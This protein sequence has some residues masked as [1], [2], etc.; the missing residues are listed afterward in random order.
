MLHEM[1]IKS[2]YKNRRRTRGSRTTPGAFF[3]ALSAMPKYNVGE[4]KWLRL[5][6]FEA[7]IYI[8]RLSIKSVQ[9]SDSSQ[10][11]KKKKAKEK[12]TENNE[13]RM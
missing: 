3:S 5:I 8:D 11:K 2:L 13:R 7:N 4:T 12:P 9:L 10:R 1:N 6:N